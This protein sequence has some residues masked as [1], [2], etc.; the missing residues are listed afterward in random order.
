M[1]HKRIGVVGAGSW[2]TALSILL[3]NNGYDIDL[4]VYEQELHAQLNETRI[5]SFFLPG[6]PLPERIRA[7]LSLEDAVCNQD[8][9]LIVV[10]THVIRNTATQL[11]SLIRPDCLIINASKGIENETLCTARQILE[12]TLPATCK[13]GTLSGPTFA[14]EIA[15]EIPSAIVA[16]A[17]NGEVAERI[18]NI[19]SSSCLK[20]FTST[21]PL[22]VEVG[23]ALK[24]VIAIATGISDGLGMG[25]NTRAALITRGLVEIT[26]IG[27]ALGARPETF[28]G[29]SGVG[30]LV[31][32]CT[33]DL[34]RNRA[35]GLQL[36][37]GKKLSQ[38]TESMKMVAEGVLTVKSTYALKS[39]LNIHAAI[40]EET[41]RVLYEKKSPKQA[42]YDLMRVNIS[43][44]FDGI[45]GFK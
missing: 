41:Y 15:K 20:V 29:L 7:T 23:G 2:G 10:P 38:I 43:S 26:R 32:T 37:Q 12:Q 36:G 18:Q 13:L 28:S 5:N 45:K 27:T 35:V 16:A 4:W 14:V 11:V 22:G 31:L 30:D 40:I 6:H 9:V 25:H 33:G 3:A 42:M 34:S 39:K 8:V 1:G 44:E 21:D 17:E 24:N 19:F